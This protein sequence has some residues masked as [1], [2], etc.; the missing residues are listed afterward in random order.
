MKSLSFIDIK[1]L[2][3]INQIY[4]SKKPKE[5]FGFF[6]EE[7]EKLQ[8]KL[9]SIDVDKYSEHDYKIMGLRKKSIPIY[10]S[11]ID[12]DLDI[13]LKQIERGE[14]ESNYEAFLFSVIYEKRCNY[15]YNEFWF[16]TT[17]KM[18]ID[19]SLNNLLTEQYFFDSFDKKRQDF[20]KNTDNYKFEI[21]EL[22]KDSLTIKANSIEDVTNKKVELIN[23]WINQ[24]IINTS[25]KIVQT[26][27]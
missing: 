19:K 15:F 1:E 17:K 23:T 6:I 2:D 12:E 16:H 5:Q 3:K 8:V 22:N 27:I 26:T 25:I 20:F 7:I 14:L 21:L 10:T 4:S 24:S 13:C 18:S 9:R 11:K